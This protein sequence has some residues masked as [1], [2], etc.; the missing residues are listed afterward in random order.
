MP[1]EF[2]QQDVNFWGSIYPTFFAISH[3][4]R[5]RG[6][7]FVT[8]SATA[9]THPPTVTFYTVTTAKT[10]LDISNKIQLLQFRYFTSFWISFGFLGKQSSINRLLRGF[11]TWIGSFSDNNYCHSWFHRIRNYQR[12]ALIQGWTDLSKPRTHASK[13]YP[14]PFQPSLN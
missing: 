13:I 1:L 10:P 11:E 2:I 12:E 8:S 7:I 6:K 4:K 5:T 9:L 3:L 14:L